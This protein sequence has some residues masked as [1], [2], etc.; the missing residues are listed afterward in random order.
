LWAHNG[1]GSISACGCCKAHSAG[2]LAPVVVRKEKFVRK[3]RPAL[4][5]PEPS[6]RLRPSF[7]PPSESV[8]SINMPLGFIERRFPRA[9]VFVTFFAAMLVM[10]GMGT[11]PHIQVLSLQMNA[12]VARVTSQRGRVLPPNER[13]KRHRGSRGTLR[14]EFCSDTHR[15]QLHYSVSCGLWELSDGI[16]FATDV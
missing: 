4:P 14:F 6:V 5:S 8:T 10:F 15:K 7:S 16:I 1:G 2:A 3:S 12:C 9:Y 11:I 13:I